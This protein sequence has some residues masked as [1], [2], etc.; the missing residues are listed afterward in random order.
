[1]TFEPRLRP[2]GDAALT[3]AFGDSINPEAHELA[4]GLSAR[5]AL[6][7]LPGVIEWA[8]AFNRLVA[9]FLMADRSTSAGG[10]NS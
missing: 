8:P 2:L 6:E 10:G 4:L 1:M 7:S 9:D 5:L 3:V